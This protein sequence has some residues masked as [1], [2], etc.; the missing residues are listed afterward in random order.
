MPVAI[1]E[2]RVFGDSR[3]AQ[4]PRFCGQSQPPTSSDF[5]KLAEAGW[6]NPALRAENS[7]PCPLSQLETTAKGAGETSLEPLDLLQPWPQRPPGE[8]GGR[9][10]FGMCNGTGWESLPACSRSR[11]VYFSSCVCGR[12]TASPAGPE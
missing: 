3:L 4:L 1:L 12:L 9:F 11:G 6:D 10:C 2:L 7:M 8:V 5:G